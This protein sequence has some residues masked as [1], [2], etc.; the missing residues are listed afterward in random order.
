MIPQA[1]STALC[2]QAGIK[3]RAAGMRN[4]VFRPLLDCKDGLPATALTIEARGSDGSPAPFADLLLRDS[5]NQGVLARV[6][7]QVRVKHELQRSADPPNL[8]LLAG[9]PAEAVSIHVTAKDEFGRSTEAVW[10]GD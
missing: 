1:N 10:K 5:R 9:L 8:E 6:Q 3:A 4:A 2:L 7:N